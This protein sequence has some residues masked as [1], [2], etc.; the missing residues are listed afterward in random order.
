MSRPKI[1]MYINIFLCP[2]S[3]LFVYDWDKICFSFYVDFFFIGIKNALRQEN[4]NPEIEEK[5][6]QLQ[7]Y[8]EKQMKEPSSITN[9]LVTT[10]N[11]ATAS[12]T[13]SSP[14]KPPPPNRKRPPSS[15]PSDGMSA[16]EPAKKKPVKTDNKDV[17]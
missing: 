7:R 14:T 3:N 1:C 10:V 9:T 16:L 5:L 6:L 15:S 12:P 11:T 4:L 2:S 17:K 8:Q 13:C